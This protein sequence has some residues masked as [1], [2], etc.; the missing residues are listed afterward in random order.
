MLTTT[1]GPP[2]TALLYFNQYFDVKKGS[3]ETLQPKRRHCSWYSTDPNTKVSYTKLY[4]MPPIVSYHNLMLLDG[5]HIA[6]RDVLQSSTL[7]TPS[8]STL[9]HLLVQPLTAKLLNLNFHPLHVVP[10]C[11]DPQLQVSENSSNLTKWRS[12]LFKSCCLMS[13]FIFNIFKCG[14]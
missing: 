5:P 8:G 10:R 2:P 7:Q 6:K 12:T 13:L 14:T 1:L 3:S 11:R 4:Y 9:K